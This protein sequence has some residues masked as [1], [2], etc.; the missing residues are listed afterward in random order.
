MHFNAQDIRFVTPVYHP[1][2]DTD[3]RICLEDLKPGSWNP[4]LTLAQLLS[5]VRLLMIC[6]NADDPL[7]AEIVKFF[8]KHI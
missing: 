6:P 2:I 1:N 3:G 7:V 5:C 4:S 8:I